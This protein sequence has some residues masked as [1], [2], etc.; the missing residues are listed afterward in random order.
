MYHSTNGVGTLTTAVAP[1]GESTVAA[2]AV[3]LSGARP[4]N[5]QDEPT[6]S[7]TFRKPRRRARGRDERTYVTLSGGPSLKPMVG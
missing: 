1:G 3:Y 6:G 2:A 4:P 5:A 7:S